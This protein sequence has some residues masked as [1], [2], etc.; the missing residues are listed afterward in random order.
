[1]R[2]KYR[3]SGVKT[4]VFEVKTSPDVVK[5][6]IE[7]SG[8]EISSI[9]KRLKVPESTVRG[10][11]KENHKISIA[12]LESLSEYVKRPL[13]VFL[14][15]SPPD[16][17]MPP[18]YR[19]QSSKITQKT[20]LAIRFAR[21][22][23]EAAGEMM[24]LLGEDASPDMLPQVDTRQ[25]PEKIALEER[26]R[27][28]L[29]DRQLA[30][31][32]GERKSRFYRVLRDAVED[33]NILVFQQSARLE[34]MRGL[35]LFGHPC[36]IL[37]NT[38]DTME[39]RRFTLMHEYGH[40]LLRKGGLCVLD[41][42][43]D[44]VASSTQRI[45]TWCNKFAAFALMPRIPFQ[46]EYKRLEESGLG[47]GEIIERLAQKF[48]TSRQATAI[49]AR[50]L[51]LSVHGF[52]DRVIESRA[53]QGGQ[54]K[55]VIKCINER[56]QKFVLLVLSSKQDELITNRDAADYL[57]IDIDHIEALRKRLS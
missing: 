45:E 11:T 3:A 22:L 55:P 50:E 8:L 36:V 18:D 49:H 7:T 27:L 48:V 53:R 19:R 43:G 21:Y 40:I 54:I 9:A 5:W 26:S 42:Q 23:Q 29:D 10:W 13:A 46:E 57:G 31:T 52:V 4:E 20:A 38:K 33:Q 24:G 56:G 2:G 51:G 16:E 15:D 17:Q 39:A 1:M 12:K 44:D 47:G 6:V 28:N 35:S 34:E 41:V 32:Q 14:L 25:S 37:V 30:T